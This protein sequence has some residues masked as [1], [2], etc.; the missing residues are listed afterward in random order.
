MNDNKKNITYSATDIQRYLNGQMSAQEMHGIET[1][2]LDDPF[3][4][5]AIEGFQTA[6]VE[7]KGESINEGLFKLNKQFRE[8]LNP[9]PRMVLFSHSKWWQISA[10]ALILVIAGVAFYNNWLKTDQKTDALAVNEK[11]KTDSGQ[12]QKPGEQRSSSLTAI[13][14]I[15]QS[16]GK[17]ILAPTT[18]S[19]ESISPPLA[20]TSKNAPDKIISR[21]KESVTAERDI[22]ISEDLV[23]Q[24][25]DKLESAK[26]KER[27][28][29]STSNPDSRNEQK[30]AASPSSVEIPAQRNNQSLRTLNN[31]SG[32]VVDPNNKPLPSASLEILQ[33]KTF[34]ITDQDGN[35][36]FTNNDSIVE[37]K[38]GQVGFESRTFRLQNNM[39][40][41]KL[42]LEPV[43][44]NLE[45][46]VV[47]YGSQR[48]PYGAKKQVATR[49]TVKIQDAVPQIGWIEYEKYLAKNKR[50]PP[51]NPLMTGETVVSFQ[52]K[53]PSELSDF[54]VENS[55]SKE[56][57]AEAI[58]LIKEGPAWKLVHGWK[59]RVTVI[60]KF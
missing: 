26:E 51:N 11:Q 12:T 13:G 22:G 34:S 8:R 7:G 45:E 38:V 46:V 17:K 33:N 32:R 47:G 21:Q 2:A 24:K 3:L 56:Y 60:V 43:E 41:N 59:T 30:D 19:T 35:F 9:P 40:S 37:V 28:N 25:A 5:D 48:K 6:L 29:P 20:G 27:I 39:A 1:A 18:P 57:D 50:P 52:V 4:A 42:V 55:L 58:R 53:R 14:D 49:K 44:E 31:F 23:M 15:Q 16:D 54:K 10:A 36:K